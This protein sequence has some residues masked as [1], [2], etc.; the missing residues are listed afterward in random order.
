MIR[1]RVKRPHYLRVMPDTP[2]RPSLPPRRPKRPAAA[3][4]KSLRSALAGAA[5]MLEH[6]DDLDPRFPQRTDKA[7]N[8]LAAYA[9]KL[10]ALADELK[11]AVHCE[12]QRDL[13]RKGKPYDAR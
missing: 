11:R 8:A 6:V 12:L 5:V 4:R 2:P 9:G 3:V 1:H 7:A 10:T 13:W